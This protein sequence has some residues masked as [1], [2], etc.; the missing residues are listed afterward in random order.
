MSKRKR[1]IAAPEELSGAALL[2]WHAYV[3]ELAEISPVDR[4]DRAALTSL[5]QA[6][7]LKN[8]AAANIEKTGAVIKLPNGYPGPTPFLK[9]FFEAAKLEKALL[10]QFGL[11]RTSRAKVKPAVKEESELTF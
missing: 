10:I 7:A 5:A 3:D 9:V 4:L 8:E 6:T 1:R 11:T 2:A